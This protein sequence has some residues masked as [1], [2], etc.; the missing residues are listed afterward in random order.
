MPVS[1]SD[2]LLST[3][4]ARLPIGVYQSASKKPTPSHATFPSYVYNNSKDDALDNASVS[5][6]LRSSDTHLLCQDSQQQLS[7]D[8]YHW[9]DHREPS[10]APLPGS[11]LFLPRFP[12]H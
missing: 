7:V 2:R 9:A 3:N 12:D 10:L 11:P 8:F 6:Q 5:Y 4:H 1:K